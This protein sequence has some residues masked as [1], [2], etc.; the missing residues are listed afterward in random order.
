MM[1]L[2]DRSITL[3]LAAGLALA[4]LAAIPSPRED[5]LPP[6]EA[7]P[8]LSTMEEQKAK[9]AIKNL[10][11]SNAQRRAAVEEQ[12]IAFGRGA[13]PL[14]IDASTTDHEGKQAGIVRCLV[15]LA[16]LRDREL[17]AAQVTSERAV[18]R[19]FAAR[20]AAQTALPALL[21]LLPELL[22]DGD[23]EVRTEAALA[24]VRNGREA[25][26]SAL[27]DA[28]VEDGTEALRERILA[29]L[30]GIVGEGS[31]R[32]L[33]DRLHVDERREREDPEG[34]AAERRAA[35]AMLRAIG[36]GA[37]VKALGTALDDS[38]NVVQRD[39]IDALRDIIEDAP[40]FEGQSI[41]QQ[42]NEVKRLKDVVR[43]YRP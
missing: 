25:G 4:T 24:L 3:V 27:A 18:L 20:E 38:H 31:H 35:V 34:A 23:P 19:R 26:L 36:D 42:I 41:F 13:I 37:A 39:A 43:R 5:D 17:V 21:D 8:E 16:D 30:D 2:A 12:V 40:P 22:E 33:V 11:N 7:P 9:R 10:R 32:A 14:L 15:E 29:A 28:F 6:V 1:R